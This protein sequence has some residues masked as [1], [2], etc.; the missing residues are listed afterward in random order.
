MD[1]DLGIAW[2]SKGDVSF[3]ELLDTACRSRG[4]SVLQITPVNLDE[5]LRNLRR[6]S[7]SLK[8]L[9]D[10]S[11][12]EDEHFFPLVH[13]ARHHRVVW[14]NSY[15]KALR[16]RDKAAMHLRLF[17]E[18][19]TPYTIILPPYEK[20]PEL[21]PLDLSPLGSSFTTK[22]SSGGGGEGVIVLC[23]SQEDIQRARSRF[24]KDKFLLQ[25]RVVPARLG[26]R[27]AWF[28]V[29]YNTG[30]MYPFW[31]DTGTH[32]YTPV[33]VAER[34]HFKLDPL[35]NITARVARICGLHLFSTEIAL[36]KDEDFQLIDYVNDP[37]DVKPQMKKRDG[38]PDLILTYLAEDLAGWL[39][40]KLKPIRRTSK[41]AIQV[42]PRGSDSK[43]TGK[44]EDYRKSGSKSRGRRP[45]KQ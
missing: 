13:W 41:K 14:I 42:K 7:L 26:D 8:A 11:S 38:V 16:A 5:V 12:E 33:T 36:S 24:P 40:E 20:K 30:R 44:G 28:R 32:V 9:L 4:L 22:P 10:R 23:T 25:A 15:E 43:T 37:V 18:I 45:D 27:D 31:W 17:R 34:Y 6:K 3:I 1:Y 21:D 35:E 29:L 39:E 19:R 2:V